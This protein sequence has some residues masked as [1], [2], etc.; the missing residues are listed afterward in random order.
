MQCGFVEDGD[1][2]DMVLWR[3]LKSSEQTMLVF[4]REQFDEVYIGVDHKIRFI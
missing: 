2:S 3:Y 1:G 4:G